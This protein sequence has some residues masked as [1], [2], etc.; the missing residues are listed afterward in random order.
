VRGER[1]EAIELGAQALAEGIGAQQ[2]LSGATAQLDAN[3]KELDEID[4][5]IDSVVAA[6]GCPIPRYIRAPH[7]ATPSFSV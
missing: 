3:A 4:A 6:L 5:G 1:D 2:E 7:P